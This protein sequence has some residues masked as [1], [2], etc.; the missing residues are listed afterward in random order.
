MISGVLLEDFAAT[1]HFHG[2]L[3]QAETFGWDLELGDMGA[4]LARRWD[5]PLR[6]GATPYWLTM[7]DVQEYL[8][9]SVFSLDIKL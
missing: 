4:T 6:G 3:P 9:T 5:A 7:A 2:E 1:D 8:T